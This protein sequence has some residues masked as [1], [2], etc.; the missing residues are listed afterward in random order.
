MN[1]GSLV[2]MQL[3]EYVESGLL[4]LS[5]LCIVV[6]CVYIARRILR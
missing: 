1:D 4:V 6:F 2:E 3:A 5:T